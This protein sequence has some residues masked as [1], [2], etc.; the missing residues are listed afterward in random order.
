MLR[1]RPIDR[2]T[3]AKEA[4]RKAGKGQRA[5]AAR[6]LKQAVTEALRRHN[7]QSR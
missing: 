2:V 5:T 3:L 1:L 4:A 7:E 6:K